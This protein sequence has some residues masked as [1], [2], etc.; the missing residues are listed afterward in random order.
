MNLG[1]LFSIHLE[2]LYQ[3]FSIHL[4]SGSFLSILLKNVRRMSLNVRS[5]GSSLAFI[6]TNE[7]SVPL[8]HISWSLLHRTSSSYPSWSHD[9]SWESSIIHKPLDHS[10]E[11][12]MLF[13]PPSYSWTEPFFRIHRISR[14]LGSFLNL[15]RNYPKCWILP[16]HSS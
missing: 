3:L 15:H 12:W 14:N 4:I 11:S 16:E 8:E 9:K 5:L 13:Q 2:V 6:I 10:L 1:S 7:I